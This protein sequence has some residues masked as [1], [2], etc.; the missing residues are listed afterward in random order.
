MK[1]ANILLLIYFVV[2]FVLFTLLSFGNI[3]LKDGKNI[4]C[5]HINTDWI[6]TV[7]LFYMSG[8]CVLAIVI[9]FHNLKSYKK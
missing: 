7:I 9:I 5:P 1:K 4:F 8:M 2:N 6:A 3:F